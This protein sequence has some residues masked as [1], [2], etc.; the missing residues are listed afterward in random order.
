MDAILK[1]LCSAIDIIC[2]RDFDTIGL[3]GPVECVL[4]PNFRWNVIRFIDMKRFSPVDEYKITA[5]SLR[6]ST[7][8]QF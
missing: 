2:G 3:L 4:G 8:L 1:K 6:I 5:Q 7:A